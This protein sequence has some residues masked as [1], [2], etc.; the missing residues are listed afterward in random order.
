[1]YLQYKKKNPSLK[2]KRVKSLKKSPTSALQ[3]QS[4]PEVRQNQDRKWTLANAAFEPLSEPPLTMAVAA[5]W[6]LNDPSK[7]KRT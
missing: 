1:L 2:K 5:F 6:G 7:S 4:R 3:D